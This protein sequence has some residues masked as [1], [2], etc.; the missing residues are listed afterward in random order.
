M[1][2]NNFDCVIFKTIFFEYNFKMLCPEGAQFETEIVD[3]ED[4]ACGR[5]SKRVPNEGSSTGGGGVLEMSS[6]KNLKTWKKSITNFF[7]NQ[8]R[9]TKSNDVII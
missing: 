6:F 8:I 7:R 9:S 1:F 2:Q 3:K 4:E 5:T